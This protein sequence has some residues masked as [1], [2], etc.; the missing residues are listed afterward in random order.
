VIRAGT[1]IRATAA[2]AL[3]VAI[4]A[5]AAADSGAAHRATR[6]GTL[7]V[8]VSDD[9]G[10]VEPAL[11]RSSVGFQVMSATQLSLLTIRDNGGQPGRRLIPYGAARLPTVS[12]DRRTYVFQI[13][14]GLR[15]SD[16]TSVTARNFAAGFE[17]VLHP[18]LDSVHQFQFGGIVGARAFIGRNA[19]HLSGVTVRR[20]RLIVR[21]SRSEPQ[22]VRN[23]ALPIVAAVPLDLPPGAGGVDAPLPSAGPYFLKEY[24]L[25]RHARLV[26]NPHWRSDVLPSR[27]A[28]VD[29]IEFIGRE[30]EAALAMVD[31]GDADVVTFTGGLVSPAR[32]GELVRR[33]GVGRGRL[34]VRPRLGR[35][36]IMFNHTRRL[37][38]KYPRLRRAVSLAIDREQLVQTHGPLGGRATDQ[39]VLPGRPGFRDWK[40]YPSRAE[41]DAARRLAGRSLHGRVA[42][43]YIADAPWASAARSAIK[44]SLAELGLRVR[45]KTITNKEF[46]LVLQLDDKWDLAVGVQGALSDD[47]TKFIN[48]MLDPKFPYFSGRY[49]WDVSR[50]NVSKW[51]KRMRHVERLTRGRERA[52]AL[53][54]RDLM[55]RAAPLVPYL[56]ENAITLVSSRVGCFS[57]LSTGWPNLAG[58][59]LNGSH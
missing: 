52:F 59:C 44:S 32:V 19:A 5:T 41:L 35:E 2:A 17:R 20:G 14:R 48:L 51:N 15:F 1:G 58:L 23:L 21:L 4:A 47:P 9:W 29:A 49:E 56:A 46:G 57:T 40:L 27:P 16:G 55:R 3:V 33:Y 24:E 6:G 22:F 53:L 36:A 13:R 10:T 43:L 8:V 30:P 11:I 31:A 28:N 25:G 37:F 45:V 50:F 54:D 39:L 26:R 42:S 34:F 12:R 7:R 18:D 38:G